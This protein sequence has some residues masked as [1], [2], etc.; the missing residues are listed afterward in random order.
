VRA[1]RWNKV[2]REK[3]NRLPAQPNLRCHSADK[4]IFNY[5]PSLRMTASP[6]PILTNALTYNP[7]PSFIYIRSNRLAIFL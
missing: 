4:G 3:P 5:L 2:Q 7:K 1:I 6:F